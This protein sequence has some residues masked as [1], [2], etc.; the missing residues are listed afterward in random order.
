MNQQQIA[1]QAHN[2][3]SIRLRSPSLVYWKEARKLKLVQRL[4]NGL[5]VSCL[6]AVGS[7]TDHV[8]KLQRVAVLEIEGQRIRID[9]TPFRIGRDPRTQWSIQDPSIDRLHCRID[10][11][12]EG[13]QL[14]RLSKGAVRVNG[15]DI[16]NF[17]LRHGDQLQ[18]GNLQLR[19]L[20]LSVS[21]PPVRRSRRQARTRSDPTNGALVVSVLFGLFTL[22]AWF[23]V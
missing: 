6:C 8:S 21:P 16:D 9:G 1:M 19:I 2:G 13:Y 3:L 22:G 18:F 20:M 4:V 7:Q 14:S 5:L 12:S 23:W 11:T 17:L 10:Q 15:R